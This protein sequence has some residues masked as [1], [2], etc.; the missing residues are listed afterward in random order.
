MNTNILIL[1]WSRC[2]HI[3][4]SYS[5]GEEYLLSITYLQIIYLMFLFLQRYSRVHVRYTPLWGTALINIRTVFFS[6]LCLGCLHHRNVFA[7]G[8]FNFFWIDFLSDK[9]STCKTTCGQS[10]FV[11]FNVSSRRNTRSTIRS[12]FSNIN[13]WFTVL[14]LLWYWQWLD[15]LCHCLIHLMVSFPLRKPG[16]YS[17][18]K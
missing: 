6:L 8:M 12:I 7:C 9:S 4:N 15:I 3:Y 1:Q 5:W 13:N 2:S 11:V 18:T 16:K 14:F 17:W 10:F